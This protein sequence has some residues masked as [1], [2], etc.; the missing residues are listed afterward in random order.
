MLAIRQWN[1]EGVSGSSYMLGMSVIVLLY[2]VAMGQ[3]GCERVTC[4]GL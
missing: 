1:L 2:R 3:G 4:D